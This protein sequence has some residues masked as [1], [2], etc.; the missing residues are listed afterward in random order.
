VL[1]IQV[2]PRDFADATAMLLDPMLL[3]HVATEDYAVMDHAIASSDIA[4]FQASTGL[5]LR[6]V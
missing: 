1:A 5:V 2:K 3:R 6:P 4:A